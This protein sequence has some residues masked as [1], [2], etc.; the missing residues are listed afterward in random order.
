MYGDL[1]GESAGPLMAASAAKVNYRG[2]GLSM[3][4]SA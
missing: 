3:E 1:A 2:L 4:V